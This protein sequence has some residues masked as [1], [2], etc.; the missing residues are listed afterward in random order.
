VA[1]KEQLS[2]LEGFET[3]RPPNPLFCHQEFLEKL[4]EHGRDSIGRRTAF[5]MQRLSVDVRRL[6]YKATHGINRGWRRS[7]LGGNH[8]SHFY[9]WWAPKNALPLKESGEFSDVPEEAVFLRDIRHHDNHSLLS[10][11]SFDAHYMPVTVRDLR[12]EEYA[13]LPWTQPQV[14]FASA[15]QPVRLLKGHPGSGK[16]TALWHAA[17]STGAERILYV[18]YSRDLA[19][20]AREYFDRFCSSHKR[21]HVVTFPNLVRQVLG[22]DA[23][24]APEQDAKRRFGRDLAP[25]ARSLGVWA[26]SQTALYDEF[27][28]HLV[29]DALPVAIGRFTGCQHPRVHDKA[30]RERRT[31]YLG[32]GPVTSALDAAARLERIDSTTLAERYFPELMLAWRTV[33][34]LRAPAN[35]GARP[36]IAAALL[37]F[38]CIAVDECQDLTPIEALLLVDLAS[39]INHQR[40]APLPLMLAGDE[41]QTVRPTDFEWGWLSDLLHSQFGSPTEYK[42]SANLRSPHRI[43][44]LVNRVW[45]LY[46]HI[47]KQERPSGSGYAE[48]ED[49]ATDQILYCT[50][51]AGPELNELLISLSTR[52]G[53]ALI[54]LEDTVPAYVPEAARGAVLT[55]SEAKGLDFHSVCV[56]DAG[57]HIERIVRDGSHMRADSDIEGLRKRLAIDQLR[58]AISRPTERLFWL[59]INPTD[60]VVRQSI[61][62]LNGGDPESGVSSC[63]P[64]ALL[65]TLE[66]DELDPEER[67]QRCQTDARQYLQV[68]PDMAWSRAQQAITLLGRPGALAAIADEAA[69]GAAYLTLAEV[70]FILGLRNTRLAPELGRPDL[71]AEAHRAATGARRFGLAL[72]LDATGRVH[73]ATA[74]NRLPALVELAQILPKYKD[75]I[76]PWL[77]VE[78]GARSKAWIEELESAVFNGH[79]AGVLIQVLPPFYEVVE[80]PDRTARTQSLQ[81]RAIQLLIKDRLFEPALEVLRALPERQ[82]KQ[83]AICHEGL[84]DLRDAAEC[85]LAAGNLKDALSCYRS[86]PDFEAAL[87]LVGQIGEHPAAESLQW[88]SRMQ[89]LVAERPEKFTKVVTSSEK[90]LLE[91]LL[92]RAL[93]VSRRKP[94]PRGK[95]KKKA[96]APRKRVQKRKEGHGEPYF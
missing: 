60:Q 88:I 71:F 79:N 64:T 31:R 93:G 24:I 22:I 55:V 6:H 4:A 90:K 14:R 54:S 8:G 51:A 82:P 25:F 9:A 1:S 45:D 86:I 27:Y 74:E 81:Q 78:L 46:S 76:E 84:G 83:E 47:Q 67:V 56:L 3:S 23:P 48:I 49:D 11:Q 70:C 34:K 85:H 44:E 52:E 10:P 69:R 65:K 89:Q 20:L 36:G 43:A 13:P 18:T 80:A 15:R 63:V 62:F 66:E 72:I 19:V 92:E 95:A 38:D 28:A 75:E 5:L 53:L 41:A 50:A 17:D 40:R 91:E 58:V 32:Q 77:Q 16:T 21:F 57:R 73:R 68:K 42:L 96:S 87:K 33:E 39:L 35:G 37:D 26:N 12:R 30:Y 61:A 2:F 59:D 7:R 94:V 29:G